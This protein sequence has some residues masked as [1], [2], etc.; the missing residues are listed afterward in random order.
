M[1]LSRAF[2]SCFKQAFQSLSSGLA[3]EVVVNHRRLVIVRLLGEGGYSFVYLARCCETGQEFALKKILAQTSEQLEL[4]KNEI[5]VMHKFKHANLLSLVDSEAKRGTAKDQS[6]NVVHLLFLAYKDGTVVDLVERSQ[7]IHPVVVLNIFLQVCRGCQC[8]HGSGKAGGG[9]AHRDIKPHNV[10]LSR[11]E[12][13]EGSLDPYQA[14]L[15]DFGSARPAR[16]TIKSR[17]E[18]L[19][20]QEEAESHTTGTYR[21][22]ELF[23]CPSEIVLDERTDVWSL[24][25]LLYYMCFGESPFEYVLSQA[26]GSLALAVISGKIN[27]PD[28]G[29][30]YHPVIVSLCKDLLK[31]DLSSRPFIDEVIRATEE[32]LDKVMSSSTAVSEAKEEG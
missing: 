3:E 9:Y 6:Q 13:E 1:K 19:K 23:D 31:Q 7:N 8:M 27:W 28:K 24:G 2:S 30:G 4:A 17:A 32:A 15:M 14:V 11:D 12:R 21:S 25:C 22:P 20:A 29:K 10:L 5:D 26:G 18:A 16:V